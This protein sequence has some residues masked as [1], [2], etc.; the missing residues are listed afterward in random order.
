LFLSLGG[1]SPSGT[2]PALPCTAC[3]GAACGRFGVVNPS[4]KLPVSF[5]NNMTDM[6]LSLPTPGG[7]INPQVR[8][9]CVR[10][11]VCGC[12]CVCVRARVCVCVR[13]CVRVC[14]C[15]RVCV[16]VCV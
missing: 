14:G 10:V 11:C 3:G 5:P 12:V 1:P 13:V 7:P 6:W 2:L 15:V 16:C 4:G 8:V 9:V